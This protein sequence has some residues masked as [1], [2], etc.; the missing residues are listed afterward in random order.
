MSI[1]LGV[2]RKYLQRVESFK[3]RSKQVF[4]NGSRDVSLHSLREYIMSIA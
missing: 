1:S 2:E 3:K 4:I